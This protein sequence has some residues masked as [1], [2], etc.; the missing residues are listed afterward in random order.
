VPESRLGDSGMPRS[1]LN[2][3]RACLRACFGDGEGEA[4]N[5]FAVRFLAIFFNQFI[6]SGII[7][8]LGNTD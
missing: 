7:T 5:G 4:R 6:D 2:D 3:G 8:T 1:R